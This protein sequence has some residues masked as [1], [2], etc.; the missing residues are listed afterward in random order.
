MP[1]FPP[2]S[3][4]L[5]SEDR[6]LGASQGKKGSRRVAEGAEKD[7]SCKCEIL[8]GRAEF[9]DALTCKKVGVADQPHFLPHLCARRRSGRL[10]WLNRIENNLAI[11]GKR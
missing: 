1:E 2:L 4:I 9:H 5:V 3:T 8:F 10:A 11:S 6:H 7:Q